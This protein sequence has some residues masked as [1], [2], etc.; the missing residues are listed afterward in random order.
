MVSG[1]RYAGVP[2]IALN[3]AVAQTNVRV[4]ESILDTEGF[5]RNL[6]MVQ[7]YP[8]ASFPEVQSERALTALS[9]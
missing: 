3:S 8:P 2:L 7:Y 6:E 4:V 9:V 5:E 1:D